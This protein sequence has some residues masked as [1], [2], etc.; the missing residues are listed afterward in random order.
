MVDRGMESDGSGIESDAKR[1]R[2]ENLY[3]EIKHRYCRT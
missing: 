2:F 1:H 3:G